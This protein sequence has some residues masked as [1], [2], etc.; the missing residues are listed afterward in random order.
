VPLADRR[1]LQGFVD[2]LFA[3]IDRSQQEAVNAI[4]ELVR[5]ALLMSAHAPVDAIIPARLVAPAPAVLGTRFQLAL[6]ITRIRKG[7]IAVIR[8]RNDHIVSR[9]VI[10]D[11]VDGHAMAVMTQNLGGLVSLTNDLRFHLVTG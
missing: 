11:I 3:R 7:M 1:T 6:D 5:I 8:D 9:A 4:N 2:W 10:D